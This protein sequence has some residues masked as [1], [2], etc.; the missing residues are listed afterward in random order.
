MRK[1]KLKQTISMLLAVLMV[2]M[3]MN[4]SVFAEEL[5]APTDETKTPAVEAPAEEPAEEQTPAVEAPALVDEETGTTEENTTDN[6]LQKEQSALLQ[7]PTTNGEVIAKIDD[8]DYTD[9][10]TFL[11]AFNALA[12]VH[13]VQLL[14]DVDLGIIT[15]NNAQGHAQ[16]N[17]IFLVRQDAQIILDLNG[18]AIT[19][20]LASGNNYNDE[21]IIGNFGVLTI[22]DSS[23]DKTGKIENT[24]ANPNICVPT[25]SNE[26]NATLIVEGGTIQS[27][28]GNAITNYGKTTIYSG[29][30]KTNSPATGGWDNGAAAIHNRGN[31][32]IEKKDGLSEPEIS[33]NRGYPVW[34]GDSRGIGNAQISAGKFTT[35]HDMDIKIQTGHFDTV[36]NVT[37][38]TWD[39]DPTDYVS[40]PYIVKKDSGGI[41]TVVKGDDGTKEAATYTELKRILSDTTDNWV[42]ILI[43]DDITVTDDLTIP[44]KANVEIQPGKTLKISNGKKVELSGELINNGTLDISTID[45]GWI[46]NIDQFKNN[47]QII[48]LPTPENNVYKI[49]TVNQLQFLQYVMVAGNGPFTGTIEIQNP[50]DAQGYKFRALGDNTNVFS[51]T[52]DGKENEIK[53]ITVDAFNNSGSLF[54][55]V[56]DATFQNLNLT[57]CDIYTNGGYLGLLAGSASGTTIVKDSTLGGK[58]SA[59]NTFFGGGLFGSIT[60]GGLFNFENCVMDLDITAPYN[61][62]TFWGSTENSSV[63]VTIVNCSNAGDINATGGSYGTI[64]GWGH[65]LPLKVTVFGY[66]YTGTVTENGKVQENPKYCTKSDNDQFIVAAARIQNSDGS[67]QYYGSIQEAV[68]NAANGDIIE[69]APGT[70]NLESTLKVEKPLTLRGMGSV[71]IM[72]DDTWSPAQA[73]SGEQGSL[74]NIDRV[75]GPVVLENLTVQDARNIDGASGHGINIVQSADVTMKNITSKGNAAAGVVVNGST[76]TA[77]G[78]YTSGN[79][80]YGVNVDQGNGVTDDTLFTLK[81]PYRFGETYQIVSDKYNSNDN[82]E[83]NLPDAFVQSDLENGSVYW[84]DFST[85]IKNQNKN[86]T[87]PTIQA[88]IDDANRNNTI[89]IPAG[90]YAEDLNIEQSVTLKKA[91][92]TEGDCVLDGN[93]TVAEGKKVTLSDL[94]AGT[95]AA[96][97]VKKG[98]NLALVNSDAFVEN[99]HITVEKLFGT[100]YDTSVIKQNDQEVAK[101]KLSFVYLGE[102]IRPDMNLFRADEVSYTVKTPAQFYWLSQQINKGSI[103]TSKVTIKLGNDLDFHN[104]EWLPVG[105]EDHEYKGNFDGQGKTISNLYINRPGENYLGLFGTANNN[106]ALRNITFDKVE[107][108]GKSLYNGGP[109]GLYGG[110]YAGALVGRLLTGMVDSVSVKSFSYN[111]DRDTAAGN[112]IGGVIGSAESIN[113]SNSSVNTGVFM[114]SGDNVGGVIGFIESNANVTDCHGNN[115]DIAENCTGDAGGVIGTATNGNVKVYNCSVK[116]STIRISTPIYVDPDYTY[117]GELIGEMRSGILYLYNCTSENTTAINVKIPND[118]SQLVGG[119]QTKIKILTVYN[120]N[121]DTPYATIQE[122]IN[123]ANSGDTITIGAGIYDEAINLNKAVNLVGPN[124]DI[125]PNGDNDLPSSRGEEAILTGGINITCQDK[126]SSESISIK[127][128]KFTKS[129]IY[130]VG[131]GNNPNLNSIT[132]ENNVFENIANELNNSKKNVSAI[133]FNLADN[134]PVQNCT[135]KNNRISGVANGDSSGIN[136]FTVSGTTTITG[137][138]IENTNHSALQIPGTAAG[139]VMITGNTFKDWDQ[140]VANGGRAMRFGKFAKVDSMTVTN[141]KMIRDLEPGEDKDQMAKFDTIPYEGSLDFSLNYWNGKLPVTT[142]GKAEDSSVIVISEGNAKIDAL[143]YYA[144][145]EMKRPL[146]PVEVKDSTGNLK[147]NYLTIPEA[148]ADA[149]TKDHIVIS[150]GIQTLSSS[151]TIPSG[152]DLT[153]EGTV[154]DSGALLTTLQRSADDGNNIIFSAAQE[155]VQTTVKN[156]NFVTTKEGASTFYSD[157]KSAELTIEGCSFNPAEGINYGGNIVMGAG[158]ENTGKLSFVNNKVN[159]SFRNGINAAGNNSVITGNEFVYTSDRINDSNRTSVLSL[160][161]DDKSGIITITDNIFK[162]ANRAIAVDNSKMLSGNNVT[163]KD[164][165]FIDVRYGFELSSTVNKGCGVYDLSK[166]YYAR[167]QP[168]GSEIAAPMLIEDADISEGTHFD[169]S[170]DYKGDQVNVY[171]Y[172]VDKEMTKTYAPVEVQHKDEGA[173]TEYFGTIAKAYEAAHAGDTIVINRAANGSDAVIDEAVDMNTKDADLKLMGSTTFNG[174]FAGSTRA[175]LILQNGTTATFTNT[176]QNAIQYFTSVDVE[177]FN[178]EAPTQIVAPTVNTSQNSFI[179]KGGLMDYVKGDPN[180]TWTYGSPSDR[181]NGGDGT[182]EKPWQ[183]NTPEQ[184]KLVQSTDTTGKYFKLTNDITVNDWTP[185]AKF[186]GNFNGNG[187]SITGNNVNFI[188]ELAKSAKVEKLRFEGFTNLVNTNNGT[189]ENCYTVGEKTT[190]IVN[191]M[192]KNGKLTDSFTAG[193]KAVQ[194]NEAQGTILRVYYCGETG[195]IGT[196][197]TKADMQKARFANTL[198]SEKEGVW[199]YNADIESPSAYP[200]VMKDDKTTTIQKLGEVKVI[201]DSSIG[202]VS[203]VQPDDGIYAKDTITLKAEITNSDYDFL[204]WTNVSGEIIGTNR[205]CDYTVRTKDDVGT[206]TANFTRKPTITVSAL[207]FNA[208][209]GSISVNGIEN[210]NAVNAEINVGTMARLKATPKAGYKFVKWTTL[211]DMNTAVSVEDTFTIY[212]GTSNLQYLAHFEEIQADKV[213]VSFKN[214]VTGAIIG[215]P[216]TIDKNGEVAVPEAPVYLDRDFVGWYDGNIKANVV[217]GKIQNVQKDTTYEARYTQKQIQYTVT[218]TKGK[219]DGEEET[220]VKKDANSR[221]T[222]IA[223]TPEQGKQFAGWKYT[224]GDSIISYNATYTFTLKAD[225]SI[226]ATYSELPVEKQPT[227]SIDPNPVQIDQSEGLYKLRF[228]VRSEVPDDGGYTPIKCGIVAKKADVANPE[229]LALGAADVIVGGKT[230]IGNQYTYTV[231]LGNLAVSTTVSARGYLTYMKNGET[232]TIYT[233]MVKGTVVAN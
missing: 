91:E 204:S 10:A 17:D 12:G 74:I 24:A 62:G 135:I 196:A 88:A 201:C 107:I 51:G 179:A 131:W 188:D 99:Q 23:A 106:N 26:F 118:E 168:D 52:F 103:D 164:N 54:N 183:I 146:V 128:L 175:S 193:T 141:N 72:R 158:V 9:Q 97:M 28:K 35:N 45:S 109:G 112:F 65:G 36:V 115:I 219:I 149:E 169:G 134:Q 186:E 1:S 83:V 61:V 132:I 151:I 100:E 78:L 29:T 121:T 224:N 195:G 85:M 48:G 155:N 39:K 8:Q 122:A 210:S 223:N 58:L 4:F 73:T 3:S 19:G 25:V 150:E 33:T 197:M 63:E 144:D 59:D 104:D 93:I 138:Y 212:A 180:S 18:W 80:W 200:F 181:F 184:L 117:R 161:A 32:A 60:P 129:G 102:E 84:N 133:H 147:G 211:Q 215:Q 123:A 34:C 38:G 220:N 7:T 57:N 221:V 199:D 162:N 64:G 101:D 70:Y 30:I 176:A 44:L 6:S 209:A 98:A 192:D 160:V 198:N 225:T 90:I 11:T 206:F 230:N 126:D 116:N 114:T 14:A 178:A 229:E 86:R 53:N 172:Y 167:T 40:K 154:S 191:I 120:E 87:Y 16:A 157:K 194:T 137:N 174:T 170:R 216:Q 145:E 76:V 165:Q 148:V 113:L 82:I 49:S 213:T 105:V 42:E 139:D 207:N 203:I 156:L 92:N 227:V 232:Y 111:S 68:S 222:V 79:G 89:L 50:I 182:A 13:T 47:G 56:T 2:F 187:Y 228:I 173:K 124:A 20:D 159:F 189:V 226:E 27:T 125:N 190:A 21:E 142:Y 69:I 96:V 94:N 95:N 231:N 5:T 208:S 143:P 43:T 140:D 177:N 185:L 171:P 15:T 66:D 127:G 71:V 67:T 136:V 152:K 205:T 153:F 37:G 55:R 81:A 218:V 119:D 75:T 217:N 110:N 46:N 163:I 31:L 214:S 22:Q 130:S 233:D 77:T 41:Y 108:I 202:K 166:N